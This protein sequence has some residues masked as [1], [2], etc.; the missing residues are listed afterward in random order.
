MTFEIPRK[1][2]DMAFRWWP[3]PGDS[4]DI[5]MA[6]RLLDDGSGLDL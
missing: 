5:A 1:R 2:W 3:S 6:H 4:V